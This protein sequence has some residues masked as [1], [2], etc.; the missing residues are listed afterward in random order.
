MGSES[1]HPVKR[2]MNWIGLGLS[3]PV[4]GAWIWI[5]VELSGEDKVLAIAAPIT[6]FI[7]AAAWALHRYLW[8]WRG[9]VFVT[10]LLLHVV[11][12]TVMLLPMS[13]SA[14][15]SFAEGLW[16]ILEFP[17]DQVVWDI[18]N[19]DPTNPSMATGSLLLVSSLAFT[20]LHPV[21]PTFWTA[22]ASSLGFSLY[23][24]ISFLMMSHAG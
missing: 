8:K 20:L 11:A 7:A 10:A 23:I 22:M 4:L 24:L 15:M 2:R 6:L 16:V 3:L 12:L 1:A 5:M 19:F 9:A 21:H 13:A 14:E 17:M 18:K